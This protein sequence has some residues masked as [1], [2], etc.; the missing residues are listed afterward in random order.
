MG[1][2]D[3]AVNIPTANGVVSYSI[4]NPLVYSNAGFSNFPVAVLA[5]NTNISNQLYFYDLDLNVPANAI[6]TG[7]Q[8]THVHG[9]CNAN[10][11][12]I[13]SIYL[14]HNAS[15]ISEVKR[16]SASVYT[17]NTSGGPLDS[18]S[19]T[20]TPTIVNDRSF[21]IIVQSYT[22]GGCTFAQHDIQ[23]EV[24]YVV[25]NPILQT[26]IPDSAANIP[27]ANG[28][29]SYSI[30]NP[31]GYSNNAFINFPVAV[32]TGN[33]NISNQ[34]YFYDLDLNIPS[35]AIVT[36]V[37]VNHSHGGCNAGS[38]TID[39]LFL[40]YNGAILGN[41][42]RDSA[43]AYNTNT[44]GNSSD[45]WSSILTLT[46]SMIIHS[47]L[48]FRAQPLELAHSVNLIYRSMYII[49]HPFLQPTV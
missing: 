48:S 21:G 5:G 24:F 16:D 31:L 2:P 41:V 14:A 29:V 9:G 3:S 33:A 35:G 36:G 46:L 4:T 13:D 19:S 28:Q 47:V 20:L 12:T 39:S 34:L 49:A 45:R 40:A 43:S 23:V 22:T 44:S 1:I 32:L 37:E 30:T 7:I 38:Y 25:C 8:V 15:I 42:K 26:G 27:V 11:F 18:W 6:I 17:S 10:S